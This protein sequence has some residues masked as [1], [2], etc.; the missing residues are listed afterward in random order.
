MLLVQTVSTTVFAQKAGDVF[1]GTVTGRFGPIAGANIREY[2]DDGYPM[3]I[4]VAD[5]LGRFSMTIDNPEHRFTVF[6]F[7]YEEQVII[8]SKSHMD[9]K[10]EPERP[11]SGKMVPADGAGGNFIKA[12]NK[13][14]LSQ[15]I[16]PQ[17]FICGYA[18]QPIYFSE[19]RSWYGVFLHKDDMGYMVVLHYCGG[20]CAD[21]IR[22][23]DKLA[24][25]LSGSVELAIDRAP[26]EQFKEDNGLVVVH[27]HEGS[28][29]YAVMPGKTAVIW[30]DEIPD[31]VWNRLYH[32]FGK[33]LGYK[34]VE[35]KWIGSID[36]PDGSRY[37]YPS[38][39]DDGRAVNSYVNKL[40]Y[41]YDVETGQAVVERSASMPAGDLVIESSITV[42]RKI[43][44][45][46]SI[47]A[48][49]LDNCT[50]VSSVSIPSS[51]TS[52]GELAFRYCELDSFILGSVD[53]IICPVNAFDESVYENAVLIV[54]KGWK[55]KKAAK[56]G[57]AWGRFKNIRYY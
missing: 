48:G 12:D 42:E 47:D 11:K 25:R 22:I 39:Y 6:S 34:Q 19:Q 20:G 10:L 30:R 40:R 18:V 5:S 35:G 1:T 17:E 26:G 33:D 46:T 44:P 7:L 57:P 55:Q 41:R 36:L 21:T 16:I 24:E 51:I 31:R 49:A 54:P 9:I 32:Q 4:E 27:L 50:S 53:P 29:V 2:G 3:N 15:P 23:D 37:T 13:Y 14:V 56:V 45:V 28:N 52:I 43:W 8:P 38:S